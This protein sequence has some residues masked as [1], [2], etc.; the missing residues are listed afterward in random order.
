MAA[1]LQS[2]L[3]QTRNSLSDTP[4]P[5]NEKELTFLFRKDPNYRT[6]ASNGVWGGIT[7]RG[8]VKLDF[9]LET[10]ELPEKIFAVFS[11]DQMREVRRE[12]S[13]ATLIRELQ[14]G[15]VLDVDHAESIAEFILKTVKSYKASLEATATRNEA[16]KETL[17]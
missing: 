5:P 13:A 8:N 2:L 15:V 14:F 7:P 11:E 16:S 4:S 9:F 10:A 1:S 12:P 3:P 17:Q 6:Y